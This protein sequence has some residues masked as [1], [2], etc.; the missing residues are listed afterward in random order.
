MKVSIS[1]MAI[2]F[3]WA[4]ASGWAPVTSAAAATRAKTVAP[5]IDPGA[6]GHALR[7][8]HV[9]RDPLAEPHY[10]A[11]PVYYR[12]YP[13]RVPAPFVFGFVPWW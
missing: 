12:P 13:Y 11:R 3:G 4:I 7:F 10:Y 2:A 8:V 6:R 5:A 9:R 1:A